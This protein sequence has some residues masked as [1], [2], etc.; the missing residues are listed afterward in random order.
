MHIVYLDIMLLLNRLQYSVCV[1]IAHSYLILFDLMDCKP[2]GS[3]VHGIFQARILEWIAI[4]FS[5]GSI[6]LRDQT[7]VSCIAGRCF[8]IRATR[9]DPQY[10]VN[11]DF[12]LHW[13]TETFVWLTFCDVHFIAVGFFTTE[14]P[15]NPI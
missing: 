11:I 1:L 2:Q 14:L 15:W 6:Q 10:S 12:S 4:Y 3:S 8:I 9:E 5:R 7:Q 13:E